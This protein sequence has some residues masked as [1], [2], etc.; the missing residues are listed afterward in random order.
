MSDLRDWATVWHFKQSVHPAQQQRAMDEAIVAGV[1]LVDKLLQTRGF[2]LFIEDR[3]GKARRADAFI[4]LILMPQP[5][6]SKVEDTVDTF[7]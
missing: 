4:R 5:R 7:D 3:D 2:Q 1:T 6:I